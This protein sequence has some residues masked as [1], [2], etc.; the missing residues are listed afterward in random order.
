MFETRSP[1]RRPC[2][3]HKPL[4]HDMPMR[5]AS[6]LNL[7]LRQTQS[8]ARRRLRHA[9]SP[10]ANVRPPRQRQRSVPLPAATRRGLMHQRAVLV[11]LAS[12]RAPRRGTRPERLGT[13][14]S[15]RETRHEGAGHARRVP[16][17]VGQGGHARRAL[18]P[19]QSAK[20]PRDTVLRTNRC[21]HAARERDDPAPTLTTNRCK[22]APK[23]RPA[24]MQARCEGRPAERVQRGHTSCKLFVWY[25]RRQS[26]CTSGHG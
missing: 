10:S 22:Q 23:P 4:A 16:G 1:R 3:Q 15:A 21:A 20:P 5:T 19:R 9:P 11:G 12:G 24:E 17:P 2:R 14:D 25:R 7:P 6:Q 18:H 8:L 13:R 26:C